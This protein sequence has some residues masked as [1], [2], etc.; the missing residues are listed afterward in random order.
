MDIYEEDECCGRRLG[1]RPIKSAVAPTQSAKVVPA[2]VVVPTQP[3]VVPA[4]V[5][6]KEVEQTQETEEFM[7]DECCVGL[8]GRMNGRGALR[9]RLQNRVKYE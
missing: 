4:K 6:K 9:G 5:E 3:K 7:D 1:R 8:K 2:K